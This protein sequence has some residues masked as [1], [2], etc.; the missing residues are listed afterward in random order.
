MTLD[1]RARKHAKHAKDSYYFQAQVPLKNREYVDF[2]K[3]VK[4]PSALHLGLSP[5]LIN[6][7]FHSTSYFNELLEF[8]ISIYLG[9]TGDSLRC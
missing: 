8:C 2:N 1:T 9:D 7:G 3:L 6:L 4:K 5:F